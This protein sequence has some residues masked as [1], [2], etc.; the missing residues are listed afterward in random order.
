MT[1]DRLDAGSRAV[2]VELHDFDD[3]RHM[4]AV[5]IPI[6]ID[7]YKSDFGPG[8]F[9]EGWRR[10]LP[11]MH[12]DHGATSVGRAVSAESLSD[13]HRLLGRFDETTPALRAFADVRDGVYPGWSFQYVDGQMVPHPSGRRSVVRITKA[14]MREF[15]PVWRPAI[16]DTRLVGI[17]SAGYA[18]LIDDAETALLSLEQTM[19]IAKRRTDPLFRARELRAESHRLAADVRRLADA[20]GRRSSDEA[21][22]RCDATL[23]RIEGRRSPRRINGGGR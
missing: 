8:A 15:G 23:R 6:V 16:P 18:D 7:S 19:Y 22:R 12:V 20:R 17:R 9:A 11:Q 14:T 3:K 10:S 2:N 5:D 4:V 21:I 13:R 1:T